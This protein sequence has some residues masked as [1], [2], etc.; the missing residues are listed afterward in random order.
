MRH[1]GHGGGLHERGR[2]LDGAGDPHHPWP[3][4]IVGA[5]IGG[6]GG[7]SIAG[8]R[9]A[10]LDGKLGHG[11]PVMGLRRRRLGGRLPRRLGGRHRIA[12]EVA[13]GDGGWC[14]PDGLGLDGEARRHPGDDGIEQ[15][16]RRRGAVLAVD[17]EAG[18]GAALDDG[19]ARVEAGA[20]PGIGAPVN[21]HGEDGAGGA[22]HGC[23]GV[24]PCGIAGD[25]VGRDDG[26]EPA[27]GRQH[28]EGR[29]DMAQ[30]GVV[31][32]AVDP[33]RRRERRV[34]EH[35]R[36]PDGGQEVGEGLGVVA[37][38]GGGGKQAR[39]QPGA[40]GRYL[41]EMQVFGGP[42]S[43]GALR[44]HGQ[45]A[46][47]SRGLQHGVAGADGGGPERGVGEGERG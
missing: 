40:N 10:G 13:A 4:R 32:D 39:E 35:D 33:R 38:D 21:G 24:A 41:V 27:A 2:M 19:E 15:L 22:A 6:T 20:A 3:P 47:A 30:I 5:G 31:A 25:A 1:G 43:H 23:E 9:P 18:L 37:G 16:S 34:H 29:A 36:R 46:G 45:N 14:G 7:G 26:G 11:T 12:E 28:R 42:A 8:V 17:R 44:H